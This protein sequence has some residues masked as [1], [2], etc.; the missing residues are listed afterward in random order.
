MELTHSLSKG[1]CTPYIPTQAYSYIHAVLSAWFD[2]LCS[3]SFPPLS[4]F[5]KTQE[6]LSQLMTAASLLPPS[7][8]LPSKHAYPKLPECHTFSLPFPSA[9][10]FDTQPLT[11]LHVFNDTSNPFIS[12]LFTSPPAPPPLSPRPSPFRG[13]RTTG[14]SPSR[15]RRETSMGWSVSIRP[16]TRPG[17]L[18]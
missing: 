8:P 15:L 17:S 11:F 10:E 4:V 1:Y 18:K 16:W 6:T 13:A 3:C 5:L 7:L 12:M 9:A 14:S 2:Y